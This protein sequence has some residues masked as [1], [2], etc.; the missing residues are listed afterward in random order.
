[1]GNLC[2]G[3][4]SCVIPTYKRNDTLIRAINS[5]LNQTYKNVEV[6]VVNDN[7]PDD[8][9]T[10]QVKE[11]LK[12][13]END[14]RVCLVMQDMHINGAKAR[15]VGI[16]AAKGEFIGFLDDDD[17]WELAKAE[18]QVKYLQEHPE[19]DA[20][21]CLCSTYYNGIKALEAAP[22]DNKNL[23][24]NVLLRQVGIGT[25][26]FLGR[27]ESVMNSPMFNI[28]LLRHQELQFFVN[29]LEQ[30][31]IGIINEHLV[32]IHGDETTNRPNLGT[33]IK[34]KREWFDVMKEVIN[35][36]SLY[37][38]YRIKCAHVFEVMLLAIRQKDILY[39]IKCACYVNIFVPAYI[40][41]I[42]R[43]RSRNNK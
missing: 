37:N 38:R 26:A 3:L 32:K 7:E 1:M 14:S 11:S 23:Q 29:Y 40:D 18:R 22:Y 19:M 15:N 9:Y 36:Y 42:R 16:K 33:I 25:P 4:V 6:I 34:R 24:F 39:I 13:Y 12:V 30:Y 21:A 35:K 28:K 8:E 20:C 17:E 5:V 43:I 41:L 2:K 27:T 31:E 10:K